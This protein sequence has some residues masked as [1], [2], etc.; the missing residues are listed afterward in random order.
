ML[1]GDHWVVEGHKLEVVYSLHLTWPRLAKGLLWAIKAVKLSL[2]PYYICSS[3]PTLSTFGR[4]HW[5][6][7]S[8]TYSFIWYFGGQPCH[9]F[10][11][12]NCNCSMLFKHL[13]IGLNSFTLS[14]FTNICQQ[15]LCV[16]ISCCMC[17]RD[18]ANSI[19]TSA[20]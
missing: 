19:Q 20:D 17:V 16:Q 14:T 7:F 11:W 9:T 4:G 6:I 8:R 3:I 13:P 2:N 18:R 1:P 10:L 15:A 5:S 12:E